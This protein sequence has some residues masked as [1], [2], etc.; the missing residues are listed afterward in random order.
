MDLFSYMFS[1]P[2]DFLIRLWEHIYIFLIS[3]SIAVVIGVGISIAITRSW[4]SRKIAEQVI[5]VTG[6]GQAVPSIAV[7][8]VVFLV[9]GI[10][11]TPAIIALAIYSIVPVVFNT[12][13]ALA[14][15]SASIKEAATGMGMSPSQVLLKIELPTSVPEIFSGIKTSATMNIGTA[16][17]ASA[18]GA[19]GLGV[20]IF[21]GVKRLDPARIF[22]VA[23]PAAMLAIIVDQLL[24]GV[25]FLLTSKGLRLRNA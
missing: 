7:I 9:T 4:F 6:I 15:V 23:F 13:S 2:Q 25:Q 12:T 22:A 21:V 8:A 14:N 3:W 17:I 24:S 18:V 10:G 16:T 11:N 19:G 1:H 20:I 5:S